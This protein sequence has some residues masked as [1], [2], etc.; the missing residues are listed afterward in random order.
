MTKIYKKYNDLGITLSKG[1]LIIGLLWNSSTIPYL[2]IIEEELNKLI[3]PTTKITVL[4]TAYSSTIEQT[5]STPFITASNKKVYDGLVAA[6][7]LSFG[8]KIRIPEIFD[9]KVF[10]VDDRMHRRFNNAKPQRIDIWFSTL[11][12]A[13]KF[14]VKTLEIEVLN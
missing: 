7:F 9:D 2:S 14:G 6:N 12:A 11:A 10:T 4:V 3:I 5:D 1:C 13:K 8:T